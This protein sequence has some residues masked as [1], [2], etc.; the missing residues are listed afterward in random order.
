MLIP[1]FRRIY[2]E[3]LQINPRDRK[4]CILET[5]L[6]PNTFKYAIAHVC[7]LLEV[8]IYI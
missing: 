4:I 5:L 1:L 6:L 3:Y 8:N 2:F 7:T